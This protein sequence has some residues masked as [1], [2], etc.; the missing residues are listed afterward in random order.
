MSEPT[1]LPYQIVDAGLRDLNRL[2]E[3]EAEC[4]AMDAWPMI[5]LLAALV[6]PG[7]VR[8]KAVVGD[9]MVGFIAGDIRRGSGVGW[10]VTLGVRQAYRRMGIARTLLQA[11]DERMKTARVRLSVRK[12]NEAAINLYEQLGYQQVETW[13]RYYV[14]GEDAFVLEKIHHPGYGR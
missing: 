2:R 8:L 1:G 14:D 9:Q 11:C 4:F 10:I 7:I 3:L 12:S 6:M 13:T 5:D